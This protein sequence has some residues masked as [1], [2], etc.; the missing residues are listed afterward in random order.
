MK[1][2]WRET[3]FTEKLRAEQGIVPG[4][5]GPTEADHELE[6]IK[7]DKI[8]MKYREKAVPYDEL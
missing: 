3:Y 8:M 1:E 6:R 7:W 5:P 4:H 2:R